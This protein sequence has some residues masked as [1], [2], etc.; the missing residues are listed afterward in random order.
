MEEIQTKA[1]TMSIQA[2][3]SPRGFWSKNY[4]AFVIQRRENWAVTVKGFNK[5]VWDFEASGN[6]NVFGLYQSHGALLVAN[7]EEALL[8]HDIDNGWDW[9]RHPG[10][11]TIKMNLEQLISDNRRYYQ[12]E[13]LAGGL[14]L[15]G[16]GDYSAGIFGMEFSQPTYQFPTGSFQLDISFTFK[17]SVFFADYVIICLGTGITSTSSST[18]NITQT[19]LFQNK[20]L[21]ATSPSSILMNTTSHSL[22]DD[23]TNE[24]SSFGGENFAA[25]LRDVNGNGYYVPNATNQGLNLKISLQTSR[26]SRG[27]TRERTARYATAW[28]N[29]GVNPTNKDYEYTIVV[30]KTPGIVRTL[31]TRQAT[32]D[33][34]VYEVLHKDNMAHVVK[35]NDCPRPGQTQYGYVIFDKS[36]RT[37]GPVRRVDKVPC[38]VMVEEVDSNNLYI[39]VSSPGLNFNITRELQT[40]PQVNA[41]ERFYSISMPVDI[42]VWVRNAVNIATGDVKEN[43]AVVPDADKTSHVEVMLRSGS[44]TEGRRLKF[45]Q[46]VKGFSKEVKLTRGAEME[47]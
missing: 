47:A 17:K 7:S 31:A 45:K 32:T 1:N 33:N 12:P 19:A 16:G 13:R 24:P 18:T 36:V 26:D 15:V 20:L 22:N 37:P 8:T 21:D 6:Q 43:G 42:Q 35:I 34:K 44:T 28:L 5:F 25:T 10:T 27:R 11:T 30:G 14:T 3:S 41:Q 40:G 38:I 23:L 39:A 29:H 2:E 9:T 46:L 4:A